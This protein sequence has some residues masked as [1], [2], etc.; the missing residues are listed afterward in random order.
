MLFF[1]RK[2]YVSVCTYLCVCASTKGY[3]SEI[4]VTLIDMNIWI[5]FG[6]HVKSRTFLS[7]FLCFWWAVEMINF[8]D[9]KC[10]PWP[11]TSRLL[12]SLFLTRKLPLTR[13]LQVR[14]LFD[15]TWRFIEV[16]FLSRTKLPCFILTIDR[17]SDSCFILDY[18]RYTFPSYYYFNLE[19]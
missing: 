5:A 1:I 16:G 13:K 14:L 11:L 12:F 18:T 8:G 15:F 2:S 4:N 7:F 10:C 17:A 19:S 6:L 3:W 9:I